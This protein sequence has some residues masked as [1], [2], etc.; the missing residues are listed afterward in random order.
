M[1]SIKQLVEENSGR[2]FELHSAYMN[3]Q[4]PRV[5]KTIGFAND[6]V[7]ADGPYLFDSK[8]VRY[9][10]FLSGY[11]AFNL[12]R[13]H[14]TIVR[15]IQETLELRPP[16]L[17]QMDTPLLAGML[18]EQIVKM[19]PKNIEKV[20]FCNSG[21]EAVE[22]AIKFARCF[23]GRE[24]IIYF[25]HAFHGLT[26]GALSLN[27]G[28][29]F[30]EGFGILLPNCVAVPLNDV[31]ALKRELADGTAAAFIFE[32]IQGKGVFLPAAGFLKEAERLCRERG[33]LLIADEI[34]TG[35][36]RTGRMFAFEHDD[37]T[38]DMILIAKSLAGGLVPCGAALM[39]KAICESVFDRM[40]RC[41]VHS[42][43]FK[44]N[45]LAM[46]A[47]LA[48]LHVL[49]DENLIA[50]AALM[51]DRLM[52]AIK[53][54]IPRYE[55]LHEVRGRGLLIGLEFGKPR[56][57]TLKMA[58]GLLHKVN[59]GLF[60]QLILVPLMERHRI[61]TQVAG[62]NLDVI[63]LLPPL[64]IDA[65]I[66]DTFVAAFEDVLKSA[67]QFPGGVWK[68][69][70]SLVKHAMSQN[71]PSCKGNDIEVAP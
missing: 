16:T 47:G 29:E 13:Y 10:D 66:C 61:L 41:V 33:T 67:H 71:K 22:T 7:K 57:V 31:D 64:V 62:H 70:Q 9:L 27:G 58:W 21:A 43:T 4:M 52:R 48:A 6:Y 39:S 14:P 3:P 18:A 69:G 60:S 24:K 45:A 65:E 11:G 12:G 15:A 40:E 28:R 35:L 32:P 2:Q 30:R 50:N 44:Q 68:L 5:L 25:E 53:D 59:Q 38:P 1:F 23:T 46:A 36:G 19:A 37:V 42:S 49:Q 63:K 8:G 34:Q 55:F 56:S 51:G 20:Y 17:V 26:C 54:L